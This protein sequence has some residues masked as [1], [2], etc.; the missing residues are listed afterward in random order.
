MSTEK[1]IDSC[2]LGEALARNREFKASLRMY[3]LA[4]TQ[5]PENP[6]AYKG[7]ALNLASL[8]IFAAA[9]I[10]YKKCLTLAPEWAGLIRYYM[11]LNYHAWQKYHLA[12]KE[13]RQALTDSWPKDTKTMK[14]FNTSSVYLRM[15]RTYRSSGK[16]REA[17]RCF[18][19]AWSINP[20]RTRTLA[21]EVSKLGK[22]AIQARAPY[23]VKKS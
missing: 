13:Y 7:R 14:E 16:P 18:E 5:N 11:G 2:G 6:Y 19:K 21:T 23:W 3:N 20:H 9:T 15:G 10:A 1:I 17:L 22:K 8:K 4:I 12:I